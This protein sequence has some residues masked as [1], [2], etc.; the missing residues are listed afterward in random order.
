MSLL[1]INVYLSRYQ[2]KRS[3]FSSTR[4]CSKTWSSTDGVHPSWMFKR[5]RR[6]LDWENSFTETLAIAPKSCSKGQR[7]RQTASFHGR[8]LLGTHA[9][10]ARFPL[11]RSTLTRTYRRGITRK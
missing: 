8:L 4:T 2:H 5:R 1:M 6:P 11:A 7:K 9:E 10:V 3:P